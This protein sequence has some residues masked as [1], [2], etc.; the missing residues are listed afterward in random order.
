MAFESPEKAAQKKLSYTMPSFL[1]QDLKK[2]VAEYKKDSPELSVFSDIYDEK[3]ISNDAKETAD[4]LARFEKKDTDEKKELKF[5]AD[6]LEMMIMGFSNAWLP[7]YLS[8]ASDYDDIYNQTDLVLELSENDGKV[9]PISVDVTSGTKDAIEKINN[10]IEK[11]GKG[12]DGHMK[13]YESQL[14][15]AKGGIDLSQV[16]VGADRAEIIELAG[17][18]RGFMILNDEAKKEKSAQIYGHPFGIKLFAMIRDSFETYINILNKLQPESP[19]IQELKK[20]C[21]ILDEFKKE[22]TLDLALANKGR[23]RVFEAIE[24][25]LKASV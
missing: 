17:L 19:R 25:T 7:G 6:I 10:V 18:Y 9:L 15:D 1:S 14:N 16:V 24:E 5:Y 23:D 3:T 2:Y 13:Y 22:K 8:K 4:K 20:A 21:S 11:I 12:Q